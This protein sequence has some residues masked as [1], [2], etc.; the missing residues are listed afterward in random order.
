MGRYG[1]LLR[2]A[3]LVCI[4]SVV[5]AVGFMPLLAFAEPAYDTATGETAMGVLS[6][7]P[8]H[9]RK[10]V[11]RNERHPPRVSHRLGL[12]PIPNGQVPLIG[13]IGCNYSVGVMRTIIV[14]G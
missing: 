10:R 11:S 12:Q 7:R 8:N 3:I 2:T 1:K 5:L 9:G 14:H 4:M 13:G 6:R